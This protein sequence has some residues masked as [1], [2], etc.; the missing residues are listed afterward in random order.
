MKNDDRIK[1]MISGYY[2]V[3]KLDAYP[4][5]IYILKDIE[6]YIKDYLKDNKVDGY[7][8][9]E[10]AEHLEKNTLKEKLQDSLILINEMNGPIDLTLL[11]KRMIKDLRYNDK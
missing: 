3:K 5:K 1:Y 7:N 6:N 8:Y 9:Y 11:I 10:L 2:G 4:R